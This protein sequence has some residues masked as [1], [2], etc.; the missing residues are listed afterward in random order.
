MVIEAPTFPG[1]HGDVQR[2]LSSSRLS[3]LQRN[4]PTGIIKILLTPEDFGNFTNRSL[5]LRIGYGYKEDFPLGVEETVLASFESPVD[6]NTTVAVEG[7]EAWVHLLT[8]K[9]IDPFRVFYTTKDER[10]PTNV[11]TSTTEAE[12]SKTTTGVP[13]EFPILPLQ[14]GDPLQLLHNLTESIEDEGGL[15]GDEIDELVDFLGPLFDEFLD[16]LDEYPSP[17]ERS[18]KYLA[19][20]SRTVE[21]VLLSFDGWLNLTQMSRTEN[22]ARLTSNFADNGLQ[23]LEKLLLNMTELEF[24]RST[25]V[26]TVEVRSGTKGSLTGPVVFPSAGGDTY[27]TLPA[28]FQDDVGGD[29]YSFVGGLYNVRDLNVLLPGHQ[30]LFGDNKVVN[31]KLLSFSMKISGAVNLTDPATL[32]F[33][34]VRSPRSPPYAEIWRHLHDG[35][36]PTF[37]PSSHR[38]V[39]WNVNG[40]G[41]GFWDTEGLREV[42]S[43]RDDTVCQS[44]HFT[45]FAVLMSIH[46]YVVGCAVAAIFLHFTFLCVFTWMA[47]EGWRL[48]SMLQMVQRRSFSLR[49]YLMVGYS[50]PVG[51]VAITTGVSFGTGSRG[52]GEGEFCWLSSPGYIWAFAAPVLLVVGANSI[53]LFRVLSKVKKVGRVPSGM[54]KHQAES[55][56]V[57][58]AVRVFSLAS[59]LGCGWLLGV[60]QMEVSP[61]FA[62]FFVVVGCSQGIGIFVFYCCMVPDMREKLVRYLRFYRHTYYIFR[63]KPT[64]KT[65]DAPLWK[66]YRLHELVWSTDSRRLSDDRWEGMATRV[67]RIAARG[68]PTGLL[69][70]W[71]SYHCPAMIANK[72]LQELRESWFH[73]STTPD[74]FL[75]IRN[76]DVDTIEIVLTPEDFGE[77]EERSLLLKIGYGYKDDFPPGNEES[78]LA[79]FDGPV[80]ENISVK[81][82]CDDAWVSMLNRN[83]PMHPIR[84]SYIMKKEGTPY[85]TTMST[86]NDITTVSTEISISHETED[87]D[88]PGKGTELT[89]TSPKKMLCESMGNCIQNVTGYQGFLEPCVNAEGEVPAYQQC[90]W[91]ILRYDAMDLI[92][93]VLTTEDFGDFEERSLLLMVG[94][95]YKDDFPG[96]TDETVLDSFESPMTEDVTVKIPCNDAWV[97]MLIRNGPIN[98]FRISYFTFHDEIQCNAST[99]T[100]ITTDTTETT[101]SYA[102][103]DTYPFVTGIELSTPDPTLCDSMG[104]CKQNLTG[105]AGFLEPCVNIDGEVPAFQQCLWNILRYDAMDLIEIVLTTEDFG[106]FEDGSL[107]LRVGY[108]YKDNFPEVTEESI[109]DSFDSPMTE[110][111]TVKI[112]CNDAWVSM[113]ILKEPM[114]PFRI[115]Y[116]IFHDEEECDTM[117]T[118]DIT[119][120]TTEISS[121]SDT[122]SSVTGTTTDP[123]TTLCDPMV[124][125]KQDLTES[126]GFLEPCVNTEGLVPAFQRCLW[127]I[128]GNDGIDTIEILLTPEDF[129][130]IEDGS[131]LL[132]IGY[133][134]KDD[135]PLGPEDTELAS[136]NGPVTQNVTVKVTS[137][138]AWVSMLVAMDPIDLFRI[139]YIMKK[140]GTPNVTME[141][142]GLLDFFWDQVS[143]YM[144]SMEYLRWHLHS[145][146]Q[147]VQ[148]RSF[149]LRFYLMVGYTV[150]VGVVAITVGVSFGTGIRYYGEGEFCWLSSPAYI[151]GFAAPVLLVVGAN[152]ILLIWVFSKVRKVGRVPNGMQ[153]HQAESNSVS[154]AVRVFSLVCLL[155]CGWLLGVLQMEV[156][157]VFA[158]SFVVVGCSQGIGIFIFYCFMVPDRREKLVRCLKIY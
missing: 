97:S 118:T 112:P 58:S 53:L 52:Y 99:T 44:H 61:V 113:Q 77:F 57:S 48:H 100:D 91:N 137:K 42:S 138:I 115:S 94:Y 145:K 101:S 22:F 56:H 123:T 146:L 11:T 67:F 114:N 3:A 128:V 90:L 86:T 87:S 27:L 75:D 129:G 125:C 35:E 25:T 130:E 157:P 65:S 49:F 1:A 134:Y 31:T 127:N 141:P 76:D 142:E 73:A 54:Q 18:N 59:L 63:R 84:I 80:T 154:S 148:R 8:R 50:V 156:S 93:I 45:N 64:K 55:K 116:F 70:V 109:L 68:A 29:Y 85:N 110:D 83:S 140:E 33:R 135:F 17:L 23:L 89:T 41:S 117:S 104:E 95:G 147:M 158:Y 19:N 43:D 131:L 46:G 79:S 21:Q 82:S 36:E 51:I 92:E 13:G 12:P 39:F 6:G 103:D 40:S 98:P 47:L 4:G 2:I 106:D 120:D 60:L 69:T 107:L 71:E 143:L 66:H 37:I 62:Y 5:M 34:N 38:C 15:T 24:L 139:S 122:D 132:R 78:E 144:A 121:S 124:I 102:S 81:V 151:W 9:M 150:P 133:G 111:V 10:P 108:G 26:F 136:F 152:S 72:I 32:T 20:Y 155:G 149:S 7:D 28:S 126:T 153:K 105:H 96:A 14:K 16:S 74:K 119:T 30:N 88:P